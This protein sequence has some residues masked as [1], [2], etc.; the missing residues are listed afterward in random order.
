M[1]RYIESSIALQKIDKAFSDY[2]NHGD[3]VQLFSDARCAI[4]ETPTADVQEVIYCK[5]CKNYCK[6]ENGDVVCEGNSC[7]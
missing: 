1:E 2:A 3:F 4:I 5:N 7:C 6:F